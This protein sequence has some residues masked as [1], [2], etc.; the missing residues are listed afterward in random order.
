[1]TWMLEQALK[2]GDIQLVLDVEALP[3]T[4]PSRPPAQQDER[5]V[6][7]FLVSAAKSTSSR[8]CSHA[9]SEDVS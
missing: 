2:Y 6:Q 4:P 9:C 3:P 1:M 5:C 7:L 8:S